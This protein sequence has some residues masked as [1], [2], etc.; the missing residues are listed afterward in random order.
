MDKK[1][2]MFIQSHPRTWPRVARETQ[3]RRL[4][5]ELESCNSQVTQCNLQI[6]EHETVSSLHLVW[7]FEGFRDVY[8]ELA[9][10]LVAEIQSVEVERFD[11]K[12][13]R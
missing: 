13:V 5:G 12:E 6:A 10:R 2:H 3:L 1:L 8:S 11:N 4:R 7:F 9:E